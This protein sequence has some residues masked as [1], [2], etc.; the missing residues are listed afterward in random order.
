VIRRKARGLHS[1]WNAIL[2]IAFSIWVFNASNQDIKSIFE[3]LQG[4]NLETLGN[5]SR[6]LQDYSWDDSGTF[7]NFRLVELRGVLGNYSRRPSRLL[8]VISLD[9][10]VLEGLS[11]GHPWAHH[12][13]GSC[14]TTIW[15]PGT[16][17]LVGHSARRC[18][19]QGNI[20]LVLK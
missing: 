7:E 2:Q 15:A 14:P 9:Y 1:I 6:R 8:E 3:D 10:K 4:K 20:R 12:G 19:L 17:R 16:T 13:G 5:Y 18:G 11:Y